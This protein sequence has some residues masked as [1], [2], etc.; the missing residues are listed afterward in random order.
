MERLHLK[1]PCDEAKKK[2][3]EEEGGE[4]GGRGRK[5]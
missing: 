4:R 1:M 3:G 2:R 5:K